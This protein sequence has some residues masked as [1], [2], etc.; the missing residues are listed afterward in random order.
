[1]TLLHR[2]EGYLRKSG[3]AATRFGMEVAGDPRLVFDIRRGRE[4]RT[5]LRDLI[6][7]RLGAGQ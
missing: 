1:M 3:T 7:S 2:I 5:H 6:E 4:P